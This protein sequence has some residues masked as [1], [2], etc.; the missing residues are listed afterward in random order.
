[1]KHLLYNG[2][3]GGGRE[4]LHIY[5]VYL[6][7]LF[8][9]NFFL[10]VICLLCLNFFTEKKI[11]I[12][13][14]LVTAALG[15]AGGVL[16]FCFVRHY[17]A[18]LLLIHLALNPGVVFFAFYP[19]RGKSF[20]IRLTGFYATYVILGGLADYIQRWAF[21]RA[22][23]EGILGAAAVLLAAVSRI[24]AR[25]RSHRMKFARV[26]LQNREC[27]V[28][29]LAFC[30]SG[31]RLRDPYLGLPVSV[32]AGSFKERLQ[33]D[34]AQIRLIPFST[35]E[36]GSNLMEVVTLPTMLIGERGSEE[37]ITPGVIGFA[38]DE[39]FR[40]K[41]YDMILHGDYINDREM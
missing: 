10:D 28:S 34:A 41:R 7:T 17:T 1:M 15:S 16:C 6:D 38:N 8:L 23:L 31:N 18:Y 22:P 19:R 27:T 33:I 36:G 3:I 11:S 2:S 26:V 21:P 37:A 20:W 12:R 29:C 40:H 14:L 25:H 32:V 13:R 30:D 9:T 5:V 35:V 4:V 24:L 39:I